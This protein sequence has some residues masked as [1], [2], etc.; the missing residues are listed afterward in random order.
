MQV[1]VTH[2]VC[3]VLVTPLSESRIIT[4]YH[5]LHGLRGFLR[6]MSYNDVFYIGQMQSYLL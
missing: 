2:W 1:K 4:D 6:L 3:K 5:G